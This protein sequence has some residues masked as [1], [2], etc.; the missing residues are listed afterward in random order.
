[1]NPKARDRATDCLANRDVLA[2]WTCPLRPVKPPGSPVH[3]QPP[4]D[5][6]EFVDPL[7]AHLRPL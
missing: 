1:M 7:V 6:A 3:L 5:S 2:F 4:Q